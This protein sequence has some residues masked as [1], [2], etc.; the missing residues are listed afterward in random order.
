MYDTYAV[1]TTVTLTSE[2]ASAKYLH[3]ALFENVIVRI[4]A[5]VMAEF[6]DCKSTRHDC[7]S[8]PANAADLRALQQLMHNLSNVNAQ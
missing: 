7:K 3:Y 8:P 1:E 2:L 6:F 4:L 5:D